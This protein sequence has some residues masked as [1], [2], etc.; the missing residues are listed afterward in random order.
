MNLNQTFTVLFWLNKAKVNS[1]GL[2]PIWIR[3]TVDGKRAECSTQKQINPAYWDSE[4]S[5]ASTDEPNHQTINGFL[6]MI[7]AEIT[8]HYNG[9]L[10]LKEYVTAEDVKNSYKGVKETKR[11]LLEI[12]KQYN[13]FL[14]EKV[15]IDDLSKR[16]YE[17]YELLY[18]KCK[19][20]IKAKLKKQ[21]VLLEEVKLNF[22]V[23]FEHHLRIA[24]K[25]HHNTAMKYAKDLKQVMKYA[26]MLEYIQSNPFEFF[27]CTFKKTKREI[28]TSEEL[29]I[30]YQKEFKIKRLEEVRDCYLFSC[31]TG[32]AYSDA[33]ALSPRDMTTGIDGTKWIIRD[34]IKTDTVENVPLLPIALEIIE[35]YRNNPYCQANNKLLPIN[36][37][38][39]YNAYLKEI[40][41]ICG[42]E[43]RLTTHT[44]RH[45]FATTI[46]LCNDVPMETA[47]ELLGHTDIRTTQ[48]YGKIVQKK[49]S[50]DMKMLRQKLSNAV[51]STSQKTA[52]T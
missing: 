49:V 3:I 50:N 35:K 27:K 14:S 41:D 48:I 40:A 8:K 5:R 29:E 47:M 31:Y 36:T 32:Y 33:E 16:R 1:K 51:E 37:N 46:L 17:R 34:R 30:L 28:L 19:A 18:R 20:F 45:T 43:K 10:A 9:L 7:Q 4:K 22:I 44:A 26:V 25:L 21:D 13:H 52:I 11:T 2:A 15:E 6:L 38:Q 23:E 42:I 12:F 39:R 24:E